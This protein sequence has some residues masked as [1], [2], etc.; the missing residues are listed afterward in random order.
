[1]VGAERAEALWAEACAEAEVTTPGERM[2]IAE[3]G[4]AAERLVARGGA[5][6]SVAQAILIRLRTYNRLA[7][8]AQELAPA[9][10]EIAR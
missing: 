9:A 4:S 2:S 8:R 1:M 7:A 6:H 3:I 5:V 10:V